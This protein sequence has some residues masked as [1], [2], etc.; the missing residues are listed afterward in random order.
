VEDLYDLL[1]VVLVDNHNEW[2][3]RRQKDDE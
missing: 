1:E 3:A 2:L